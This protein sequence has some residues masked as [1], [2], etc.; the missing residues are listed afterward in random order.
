MRHFSLGERRTPSAHCILKGQVMRRRVLLASLLAA[1]FA[2]GRAAERTN[3]KDPLELPARR[4]P[5]AASGELMAV[6][7]A[8]DRLV[9]V[10]PKGHILISVDRGGSWQQVDCPVSSDLVAVQFPTPEIGWAVGHDGVALQSTDG[11]RT[12]VKRLDGRQLNALMSVKYE[13]LPDGDPQKAAILKEVKQFADEGP[14]KPLLD[15][16][17]LNE[18]EGFLVG[19]FNLIFRTEDGGKNWEPWYERTENPKRFHLNVMR[20]NGDGLYVVGEQGLVM[21]LDRTQQRFVALTSPYAGSLFGLAVSGQTVVV[22]GLRGNALRSTDGGRTWSHVL[23]ASGSTFTAAT[24]LPDGRVVMADLSGRVLIGDGASG[25]F[26]ALDLQRR[27]R[28]FGVTAVNKNALALAGDGGIKI[29]PL[30]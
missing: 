10:G 14:A 25:E 28:I 30:G 1:P 16:W 17:F 20:G 6:A 18:N 4:T 22:C 3:F 13:K 7:S 27:G 21:R 5:L 11:G 2:I 24:S 19:A 12:W 26:K 9:A 15:V 23:K 8:G 29:V